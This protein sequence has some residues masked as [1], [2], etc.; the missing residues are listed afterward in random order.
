MLN[1]VFTFISSFT[2]DT[3]LKEIDP[4]FK[5]H[6]DLLTSHVTLRDI[7]THRTGIPGYFIAIMAG[8][9][10]DISMEDIVR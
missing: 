8:Y 5:L 1:K 4:E 3:P 2:W 9:P 10:E 7:L 6:S